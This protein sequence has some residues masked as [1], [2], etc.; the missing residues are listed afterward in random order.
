MLIIREF[1]PSEG[2]DVRQAIATIIA[3]NPTKNFKYPSMFSVKNKTIPELFKRGYNMKEMTVSKANKA[4]LAIIR[5][6]FACIFG[7]SKVENKVIHWNSIGRPEIV[8]RNFLVQ[9][10]FN[11]LQSFQINGISLLVST[12]R[13]Q[14]IIRL[15][16]ALRNVW[17]QTR[18][19]EDY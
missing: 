19:R 2:K 4:I 17:W 18:K 10:L 7:I 15:S 13:I 6:L 8:T 14:A 11:F 3:I 1:K 5:H 16:P 12:Y 9:Y